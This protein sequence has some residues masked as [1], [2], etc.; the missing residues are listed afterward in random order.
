MLHVMDT[1]MCIHEITSAYIEQ[2]R[3]PRIRVERE[4]R[5]AFEGA[6]LAENRNAS[7]VLR[8]FMQSYVGRHQGGQGDLFATPIRKQENG[9]SLGDYTTEE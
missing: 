3:W 8:E 4:L 5:E 2:R 6:Y 9:G 1:Q 7:N